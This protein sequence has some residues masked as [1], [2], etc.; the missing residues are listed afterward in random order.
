[1]VCNTVASDA[2]REK[3]LKGFEAF[4]GQRFHEEYLISLPSSVGFG[5]Q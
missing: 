3:S 4:S 1:V 5:Y 2:P